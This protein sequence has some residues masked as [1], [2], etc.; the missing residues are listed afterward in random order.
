MMRFACP[1]CKATVSA[2]EE[3]VG[4]RVYCPRCRQPF[5]VPGVSS[6]AVPSLST[7][8][9]PSKPSVLATPPSLPPTTPHLT[10]QAGRPPAETPSTSSPPRPRP[11]LA[12]A[13]GLVVGALLGGGIVW[14]V[15]ARKWG[16]W[17]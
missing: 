9:T 12:F 11:L 3:K 4:V 1:H 10:S 17:H 16:H 6:G 13:A 14:A 2:P 5:Q 8:G 7:S 15:L